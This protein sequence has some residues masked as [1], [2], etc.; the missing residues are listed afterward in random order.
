MRTLTKAVFVWYFN[1]RNGEIM[2]IQIGRT[3]TERY[4]LYAKITNKNVNDA[5]KHALDDWMNTC[6][7]GH[8]EIITGVPMDTE[9]ERMGLHVETCATTPLVN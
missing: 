3:L 4:E 6:G 7:E 9:A 2:K 1:S 5:I 8:I